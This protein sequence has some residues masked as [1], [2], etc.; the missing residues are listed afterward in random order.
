MSMVMEVPTISNLVEYVE[1]LN[2]S[3]INDNDTCTD[4]LWHVKISFTNISNIWWCQ[5]GGVN[6]IEVENLMESLCM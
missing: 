4:L 6:D 3:K 2:I 5:D 1:C